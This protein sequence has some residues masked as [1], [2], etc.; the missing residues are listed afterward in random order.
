MLSTRVR[1]AKGVESKGDRPSAF[2][3]CPIT[4]LSTGCSLVQVWKICVRGGVFP[5]LVVRSPAQ[6]R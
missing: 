1:E 5:R 3:A 4:D 6:I 2:N